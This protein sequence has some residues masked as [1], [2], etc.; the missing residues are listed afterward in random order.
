MAKKIITI[1]IDGFWSSGKST[2]AKVLAKNIGY[3]YIDSG[4]MYRAITLFCIEN[5]LIDDS[6]NVNETELE[7]R[8]G[9]VSIS[10]EVNPTSGAS[11]VWLDGRNVEGKIRGMRVSNLVSKVAALPFVRRAMVAQQQQMGASKGIVMDGRDIGTTVF[12]DAEMKVFVDASAET[13]AHRRYAELKQR[14]QIASYDEVYRN[15]CERDHLDMTRAES[16]LRKADDAYVLDNSDMTIAQQ[17]AWLMCL[18]NKIT[19]Q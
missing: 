16:P 19:N 18:Y 3:A 13:R 6:G 12:P 2:M 8:I 1:A 10:F 5:A 11:E 7:R 17:N 4:A 9:N 15:V 14:G